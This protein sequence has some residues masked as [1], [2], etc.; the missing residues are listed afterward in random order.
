MAQPDLRLVAAL[1]QCEV[2]SQ[3]I[4]AFKPDVVACATGV[5]CMCGRVRP[6][7]REIQAVTSC[8]A[9]GEV[10]SRNDSEGVTKVSSALLTTLKSVLKVANASVTAG[11]QAMLDPCLRRNSE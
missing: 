11:T 2:L 5:V 4:A 1:A 7:A 9:V 10:E 3:R 8:E 6:V